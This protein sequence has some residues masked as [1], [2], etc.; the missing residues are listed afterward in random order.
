MRRVA[1]R[2][3]LGLARMRLHEADDDGAGS[4]L[5]DLLERERLY[6]EHD[7]GLLQYR[8]GVEP[9]DVLV[10]RVGEPCA[11]AGAALHCDARAARSKFVRDLRNHADAGFVGRCLAQHTDDYTHTG[12]IERTW[13]AIAAAALK[14]IEIRTLHVEFLHKFALSY[15]AHERH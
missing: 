4:E 11:R 15:S 10:A 2:G 3:D 1:Q 5:P 6:G 7:V 8:R 12:L 14:F 9:R 13:G